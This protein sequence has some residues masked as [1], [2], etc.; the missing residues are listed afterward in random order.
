MTSFTSPSSDYVDAEE[1]LV[2]L[3]AELWSRGHLTVGPSILSAATKANPTRVAEIF[4]APHSQ[5]TNP[6][7][8]PAPSL[9]SLPAPPRITPYD[10]SSKNLCSFCSQLMNQLQ[11]SEEAFPTEI[12]KVRFAYQCLGRDA[13]LK[14]R[15]A[16]RCL[17]DLGNPLEITTLKQ[18]ISWLKQNCEDPTQLD[19]ASYAAE[20]LYRG[21]SSFHEFIPTFEDNMAD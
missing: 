16:F 6:I 9:S 5:D 14:M 20:T 7:S 17:E 8:T 21:S 11:Y 2:L 12:A 18:F 15:A 13:V 10:G 3:T 4:N 19:N 1:S